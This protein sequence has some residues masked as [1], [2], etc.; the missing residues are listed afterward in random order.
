MHAAKSTAAA[1]VSFSHQGP[2]DQTCLV[3]TV[4]NLLADDAGAATKRELDRVADELAPGSSVFTNPHK[5]WT[6]LGNYDANVLSVCLQR[7]GINVSYHDRRKPLSD[8]DLSE[9]S[10][11]GLVLNAPTSGNLLRGLF[12]FEGRHWTALRLVVGDGSEAG[13]TGGD[14]WWFFDSRKRGPV[15]IGD[16]REEEGRAAILAFLATHLE[17]GGE[18]LV[19]T[20]NTTESGHDDEPSAADR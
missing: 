3:H 19:A 15:R 17:K 1:P 5:S 14:A 4:N 6:G 8:L 18:V 11:V 16:A 13:A 2:F 10:M 7:R 20:R 12:G 9:G